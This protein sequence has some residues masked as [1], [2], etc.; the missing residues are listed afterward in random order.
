MI[1]KFGYIM[2]FFLI[3]QQRKSRALEELLPLFP[4]SRKILSE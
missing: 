1:E 3:Q 4:F 2:K